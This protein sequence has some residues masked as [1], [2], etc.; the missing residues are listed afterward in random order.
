MERY[1]AFST[2]SGQLAKHIDV[3]QDPVV[4][5]SL[6][7]GPLWC[8]SVLGGAHSPRR[9]FRQHLPPSRNRA[10]A[11]SGRCSSCIPRPTELL[12]RGYG[13]RQKASAGHRRRPECGC[14]VCA[15]TALWQVPYLRN[16]TLGVTARKTS[17]RALRSADVH[18][19]APDLAALHCAAAP[20]TKATPLAAACN[21]SCHWTSRFWRRTERASRC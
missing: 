18:A 13:E 21:T 6:A 20:S 2:S 15:C 4:S 9:N 19:R 10:G 17:Q 7:T 1:P 5:A 11:C 12:Q 16:N 8:G 14:G 3:A